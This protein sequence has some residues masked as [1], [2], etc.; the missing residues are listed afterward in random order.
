MKNIL[1]KTKIKGTKFLLEVFSMRMGSEYSYSF[2]LRDEVNDKK[3][4]SSLTV[5]NKRDDETALSLIML[6][7]METVIE[8]SK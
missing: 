2:I 1:I 8:L 3:Y 4:A 5:D 6:Q 7:V